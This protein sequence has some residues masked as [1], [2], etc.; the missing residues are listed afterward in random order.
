MQKITTHLWYDKVAREA[1]E[2]Y[3]SI[4]PQSKITGITT[5]HDTPSGSVD[6]VTFELLGREFQAISAGPYFKFNPS[7]SL[8][9]TCRTAD[10][11]DR[12]WAQLAEGGI[13]LMELGAYPFSERYGWVQDRYGLSW[14]LSFPGGAG[15]T[16]TIRPFLMFVGS[17]YGRAEEAMRFWTSLFPDSHVDMIQPY[18]EGEGPDKPGKVKYAEF[19]LLGRGFAVIDSA[20]E[21]PFAFNEAVS[22]MV[23]CDTQEEIDYYWHKLSAVPE[24]EQ[25]GWLKDKF[26]LSWQI[27]SSEMEEMLA[28]DD[29][30]RVDRVTQAFLQMKK[31][32]T[33]TLRKAFEGR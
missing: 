6:T 14:Q 10:D 25:C 12:L 32:D 17:V 3:V 19:S 18:G 33:A 9:V 24:A 7:V 1:A 4:L 26:G 30:V 5:L 27:V 16:P 22:F 29:R 11:V 28:S 21:H 2:F 20:Y 31:I 8:H 23:Y 15:I 13:V